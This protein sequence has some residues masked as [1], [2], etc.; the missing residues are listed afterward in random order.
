MKF[1]LYV[2]NTSVGVRLLM[3]PSPVNSLYVGRLAASPSVTSGSGGRWQHL[4]LVPEL[5]PGWRSG[6][7]SLV[8]MCQARP[9]VRQLE[10]NLL[11]E[12]TCYSRA[13]VT[14]EI[15][16]HS[17]C[18]TDWF[19]INPHLPSEYERVVFI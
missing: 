8:R 13:C 7:G 17:E 11:T 5:S 9:G 18:G 14:R 4:P 6:S 1:P 10:P 19:G 15:S 3:Y 2:G 16:I 12:R